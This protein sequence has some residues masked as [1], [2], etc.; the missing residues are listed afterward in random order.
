MSARDADEPK[1]IPH[2]PAGNLGSPTDARP[3]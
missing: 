3:L 2:S 1:N